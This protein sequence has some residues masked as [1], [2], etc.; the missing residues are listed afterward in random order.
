MQGKPPTRFADRRITAV[1]SLRVENLVLDRTAREPDGAI[2]WPADTD[3][4][5]REW[6]CPISKPVRQALQAALEKR[7]RV[8]SRV[9]PGPLFPSPGRPDRALR[10][11]EAS[12]W[13]REAETLARLGPQKGTLWHAYRRLWATAHKDLPNVDVARAGGWSSVE[14]MLASYQHATDEGVLRVVQH[15]AEV[16]EVR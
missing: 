13:L 5:G 10:Y 7:A 12:A 6:R 15:E 4:M 16:R 11:E 14:T 2:I 8:L 1:C 3:K 9:G